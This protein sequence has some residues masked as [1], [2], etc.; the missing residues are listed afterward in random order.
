MNNIGED[1][2]KGFL[3]NHIGY[4]EEYLSINKNNE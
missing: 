1:V 2:I 3:E 4:I